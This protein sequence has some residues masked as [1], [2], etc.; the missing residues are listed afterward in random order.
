MLL[1][2]F[3]FVYYRARARDNLALIGYKRH[4]DLRMNYPALKTYF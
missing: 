2:V 3:K 1:S 4:P